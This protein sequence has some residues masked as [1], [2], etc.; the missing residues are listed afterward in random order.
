MFL[1]TRRRLLA[2]GAGLAATGRVG[3]ARAEGEP[4]RRP[5]LEPA[6]RAALRRFLARPGVTPFWHGGA[7]ADR[8]LAALQQAIGAAERHGL[9]PED[10]DPASLAG[11]GADP[12]AFE[13]AA[14]AAFLALA[15]DLARGRPIPGLPPRPA[16]PAEE[17]EALLERLARAPDPAALFAELAPATPRYA[18]LVTLLADLRTVAARGGWTPVPPVEGKVEPGKAHP[19]VVALRWRLV[20]TDGFTGPLE[21]EL[22]DP[23]LVTALRRFQERHGLDPDGVLG[24]RTAA[25]LAAPVEWRIGQVILA[26]ERLRRLPAERGPRWLLVDIAGFRLE[27]VE[28]PAPGQEQVLLESPI[29]VGTRYNQTPELTARAVA[30]TLNPYWHVPRSIAVKEILPDVQKD[31]AW[32][33]RNEMVVFDRDGRRVDPA[34]VPWQSLGRGNFP[35]RFRQHWGPKNPLGRIKLEMPNDFDVYLHDTPK[36]EL[37]ARSPRTFSHGCMRV[38]RMHELAAL[39]L[40]EQGW[41]RERIE[42]AIEAGGPKTIPL[43]TRPLVHVTYLGA[44]VDADGTVR[45]REDVYGRDARLARS[46]GLPFR[47]PARSL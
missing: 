12:A 10:Y 14:T 44:T 26:M 23:P 35:Y 8:R 15:R 16:A 11:P 3:P 19:A 1:L 9:E 39:L 46:L 43:R 42:A 2:L 28:E 20:E 36:K 31:P 45:F 17:P 27:L 41:D 18:R 47:E 24:R 33:A 21:G 13:V 7:A 22:L 4:H 32:L 5:A 34:T 37:F 6:E 25:A 29:I 38:A 40:A 30:V